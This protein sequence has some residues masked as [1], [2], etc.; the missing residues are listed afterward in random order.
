METKEGF[1]ITH[2]KGFH[3]T[4]ENGW[5][6]SVQFG[7]GNYCANR[8]MSPSMEKELRVLECSNAEVWAWK[9]EEHKPENPE[10]WLNPKE[11]LAFIN[12]VANR[13]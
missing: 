12:E 2:G 13:N 11:V 8:D 9:E 1:K 3:I 6:I 4:F 10:G 7:F 5:T